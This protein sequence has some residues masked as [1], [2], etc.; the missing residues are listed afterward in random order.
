MIPN[1]C[2]TG[3]RCGQINNL[4]K[5]N[6]SHRIISIA[7]CSLSRRSRIFCRPLRRRRRRR[8]RSRL[9][10]RR[11]FAPAEVVVHGGV[12]V[13]ECFDDDVAD[14]SVAAKF[15]STVGGDVRKLCP[16][17]LL[18]DRNKLECLSVASSAYLLVAFE[19]LP[20]QKT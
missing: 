15:E 3:H 10:R 4:L 2:S 7:I 5:T 19:V 1:I 8:R 20:Y 18:L 14:A 9:N 12:K 6:P 16:S 13:A 17:S 11:L